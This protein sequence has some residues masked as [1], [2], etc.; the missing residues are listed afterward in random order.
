[1]E[2]QQLKEIEYNVYSCGGFG[3]CKGGY[4]KG[5]S[6]CPM[7]MASAG[8]EAETP[9][10]VITIAREILE[11]RLEYSKEMAT[12]LYRCTSCDNCRLL[13][14]A[15]YPETGETLVDPSAVVLSMKA[16][17]VENGLIPRAVRD[18]LDNVYRCGN[19]YGK[20]A[21][22]RDK[23]TEG[24]ELGF[25]DQEYLFYVGCV[26]SYDERGN[27][28]ARALASLLT[29]AG[30]SFG[31][32]GQEEINDGNEVSHLGERGLFQYLAEKNIA[33]FK[34]RGVKKIVTLSPH[35]YNTI[36]NDYPCLGGNFEVVHY[37]QLLNKHIENGDLNPRGSVSTK[38]TYHDPCFLGRRNDEYEAP[39]SI[40]H[41]IPGFEL[42]EM[43]RNRENALCCG[44]G[45]GNLFTDMIGSDSNSPARV[46]V[47]EA[48]STGASILVVACP[49]C[50]SMFE[51]AIKVEDLEEKLTVSDLSE[52]LIA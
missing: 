39:R 28:M 12:M 32:L 26:G 27:K 40:I 3:V 16:D 46:R 47:R 52:L 17:L 23:W 33:M 51:D 18:F 5:V 38:V 19:P 4:K 43:E 8:F 48:V 10:G 6:P 14:G 45:G 11:G 34:N 7:H 35:A 41:S 29:E 31:I 22:D 13:C 2:T 15:V 49:Y 25:S 50:A 21:I 36:K 20:Q 24:L 37:S 1:M 9:R 30:M 42:V 44:G